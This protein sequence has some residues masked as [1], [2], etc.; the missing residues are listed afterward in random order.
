MLA[1]VIFDLDGVIADTHP[2]HRQAW[3]QLLAERGLELPEE[4]LNFIL[5]GRKREEILRHFL[6]SLSAADVLSCGQRKDELFQQLL[7]GLRC[8][9]GVVDLVW[10][11]NSAGIAIGVATSAGKLRTQLVLQ[12]LGLAG[13][14]CAVTTGDDIAIGK[15][16]PSIFYLTAK[17]MRVTPQQS[18]VAEDSA[19]GVRGAK[20][21]GMKCLGI[22]SGTVAF[23][24]YEAGA[25]H[26]APNFQGMT[27]A[28]LREI[29][30]GA[31]FTNSS[32]SGSADSASA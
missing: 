3:R 27:V 22:A 13:C 11:L 18:L 25:D 20:A 24:L 21:A 26:V 31:R 14:F 16:D 19:V 17:C 6:G 9:P 5:E 23:K 15:P 12:Q 8:I 32:S 10:Q 4:K 2:I 7:A 30:V 29:S 1:G 28:Q